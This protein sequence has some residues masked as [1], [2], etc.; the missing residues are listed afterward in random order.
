MNS[1]HGEVCQAIGS[2][3]GQQVEIAA[4]FS[5]SSMT[6]SSST[7]AYDTWCGTSFAAPVVTATAALVWT[8]F[9]SW[10]SAQ[11]RQRLKDKAIPYSPASQF[12]AGRVDALFAVHGQQ[13]PY[14]ASITGPVEVQPYATCS[15]LATTTSPDWPYSYR[16]FADGVEL[17]PGDA[18]YYHT[19]GAS[20]FTLMV[21]VEDADDRLIFALL[22]VT[23]H[24]GA[25]ECLDQ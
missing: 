1:P 8:E 25:A 14:T 24:G 21:E 18:Y 6:V 7:P 12:G 10:T 22:E 17:S 4:P 11:V 9:P 20:S 3:A 16:W 15:W 5:A 2:R 19:V 13:T 23:V